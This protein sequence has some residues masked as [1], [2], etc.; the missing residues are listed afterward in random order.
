M[1]TYSLSVRLDVRL[2]GV[3]VLVEAGYSEHMAWR[4]LFSAQVCLQAIRF[5]SK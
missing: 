3:F 2:F 4:V 5:F 1:R